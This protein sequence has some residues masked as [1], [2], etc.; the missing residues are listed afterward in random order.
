MQNSQLADYYEVL[1]ISP[2]AERDTIERVFRYMAN[3]FHPDNRDTGNA[4]R[5]A[6]L[7]EAY[8]VLSDAS[9]RAKYDLTYDK[10]REGRWRL[11]SEESVTSDIGTD[12]R[13]RLAILSLLYVI[14]R[15]NPSEPGMGSAELERVLGCPEP[16]IRFHVWYLRE[17]NYITRL[18]TGYFAITAAGVDR[19]VE[20]GG[21]AS[22]GP[23]LLTQGGRLT[24]RSMAAL[25]P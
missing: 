11:F 19:V 13:I 18:E 22:S 9:A 21:P 20:L 25:Q 1:Q 17:N 8:R 7:V 6:E 14:R 12:S 15:N 16:V 24:P 4:E 5:F 23:Q 10:I 3:R 2:R